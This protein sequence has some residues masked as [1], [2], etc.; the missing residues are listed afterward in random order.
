MN[1]KAELEQFKVDTKTETFTLVQEEIAKLAESVRE[2]AAEEAI[3]VA[4]EEAV[5]VV[6]AEAHR[7]SNE[8]FGKFSSND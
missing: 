3:R 6:K 2:A 7:L 5:R 8:Q 1:D 4:T